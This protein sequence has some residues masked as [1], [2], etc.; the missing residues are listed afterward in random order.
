[1]DR[2]LLLCLLLFTAST[3][4]LPAQTDPALRGEVL[5]E[6]ELIAPRLGINQLNAQRWGTFLRD[7]GEIVRVRERLASDKIE[8]TE[9]SRGTFRLVKVYAEL[10]RDGKLHV[11]GHVFELNKPEEI[12]AWLK[13]LKT[14]GAQGSPE[15][16][17]LWGL[18]AP[19]FKELY[20]SLA[21]PVEVPLQGQPLDEA[22]KALQ[23]PEPLRLK[24]E[25]SAADLLLKQ[26]RT[27]VA[28]EVQ[29][30]SQGTALAGV[31]IQFGLGFR[32][33]RTP[34][35]E[36]EL[37]IEPLSNL[38]DPWP[39][40][41]DI[42]PLTPRN[43]IAPELYEIVQTGFEGIPREQVLQEIA[44]K[45][46]TPIIINRP[47]CAAREIDL[48]SLANYPSKRTGWALILQGV[49]RQAGLT[50]SLRHDE[51][52]RPVIVV[53]PFEPVSPETR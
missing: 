18:G 48:M 19:R 32:P 49:V 1:M 25:R 10:D 9:H 40:G 47:A 2:L 38:T 41:W 36:I 27:L 44:R 14:Y 7:Q 35:N 34:E 37:V 21:K 4:T 28:D 6:L 46:K 52:G 29:G 45:T 16:Q 30:L 33:V 3:R 50:H 39:V 42:D 12:T 11:P 43:Q 26:G 13:E 22:L 8:V 31:L 5:L 15:G 20:A 24:S 17:P 51:G 23:P 53:A